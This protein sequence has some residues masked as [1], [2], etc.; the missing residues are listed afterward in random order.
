MTKVDK[1]IVFT[2]RYSDSAGIEGDDETTADAVTC[3]P[4]KFI[5]FFRA[6]RSP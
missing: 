2:L 4:D 5:G 3:Y 6:S 1:A